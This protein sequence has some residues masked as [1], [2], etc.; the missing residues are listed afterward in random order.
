[1]KSEVV[2][3]LVYDAEVLARGTDEVRHMLAELEAD[4]SKGK[5]QYDTT[6]SADVT[7]PTRASGPHFVDLL[8]DQD[9]VE[10][11]QITPVFPAHGNGHLVALNLAASSSARAWSSWST[12]WAAVM[13]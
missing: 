4:H 9:V 1:M 3:C 2:A 5:L 13:V 12:D 8:R 11:V 10:L 6:C 7:M